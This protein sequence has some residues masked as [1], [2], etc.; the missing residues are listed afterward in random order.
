MLFVLHCYNKAIFFRR[1]RHLRTCIAGAPLAR[2]PSLPCRA[3][4]AASIMTFRLLLLLRINHMM[5]CRQQ[6]N[7]SLGNSENSTVSR[8]APPQARKLRFVKEIR[9]LAASISLSIREV[10]RKIGK[11]ASRSRI[12]EITKQVRCRAKRDRLQAVSPQVKR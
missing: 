12:G 9:T 1:K 6:A 3:A 10:H 7:E 8:H 2:I 11:R 5:N 4:L